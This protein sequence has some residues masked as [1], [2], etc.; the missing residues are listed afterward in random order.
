MAFNGSGVFVR[1]YN[2]VNDAAAN[3]KIRADRMD[4]EM[5]GFATGLSTCITKDGQTTITANLPMANFRHTGVGAG[6]ARTDYTRLDQSQDGKLAWVDGGGTADAIT[7]SYSIPITAL[8]DGQLCYVRATAANATTTPTFSPSAL[9]ARTIVKNGGQALAAGDIS[10]DGHELILRYDLANTRWELMNPKGSSVPFTAASASGAASLDFAEDT[11]NGT[12]KVTLTAAASLAADYTVTLPSSSNTL[13]TL[14][15]T[16]TLTNKSLTDPLISAGGGA[17]I[18]PQ[19]TTPAPTTD[20]DIRWDSDDNRIVV[21]DGSG[22]KIFYPDVTGI[23]LA[24]QQNSTSGTSIDFTSIPSGTK[25]ITVMLSGVSTSG[26]NQL[27]IQLGD[28]GGVET[29]GYVGV[30]DDTSSRTLMSSAGFSDN[31]SGAGFVRRA[32]CRLNLMD[33]A[34]NTWIAT[35]DTVFDNSG[36][37]GAR[38]TRGTKA[39][40]ATL[41]RVRITTSGGTDTFDAGTINISYS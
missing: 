38:Y 1:L 24:T 7:A 3:I 2:W 32:V 13:A 16:E 34:T 18:L 25:E 9:T 19:S 8:V 21:G 6:A 23:V 12:N 41:D 30:T 39:L 40:T 10:G 31:T 36:S 37:Y 17:L 22:Q 29:S 5:N 33:S 15:G 20:G 35:Y 4:N 26:T 11:D 28:S 27:L 14:A